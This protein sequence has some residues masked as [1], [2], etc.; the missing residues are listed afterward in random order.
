MADE[1]DDYY[2]ELASASP[3]VAML[4]AGSDDA[5]VLQRNT[6]IGWASSDV[7][8]PEVAQSMRDCLAIAGVLQWC[9]CLFETL[10][11]AWY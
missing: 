3:A 6:D 7:L 9:Y 5:G 1:D 4:A 8:A 2:N 10:L 11:L